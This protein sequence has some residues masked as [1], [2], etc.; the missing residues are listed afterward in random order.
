MKA[1]KKKCYYNDFHQK[2]H[3]FSQSISFPSVCG[4]KDRF[5][6]CAREKSI[7]K[8]GPSSS[9]IAKEK[10]RSGLILLITFLLLCLLAVIFP[11]EYHDSD[12]SAYHSISQKLAGQPLTRWGSPEWW[13][14]GHNVGYFR[15]H[16]PGIFWL[17]AVLVRLGIP[18]R[19]APLC[20]NF[21]YLFLLL[22][23]LYGLLR[24]FGGPEAG[25]AAVFAFVLTPIFAQYLM[26]ANQELP[27]ALA[28]VAGLYGLSRQEESWRYAALYGAAMLL[29]VFIKGVNALT[30]SL[31]SL[32]F[33][34]II[35]RKRRTFLLILS[36][37]LLALAAMAGFELWYRASTGGASFLQVYLNF[38]G[39]KAVEAGFRP[40]VK[41]YNIVW[42]LA[43]TLWFAA[44][45]VFILIYALLRSA[46]EKAGLLRERFLQLALAGSALIIL[47]FS[48]FD[49]RADRYIF[50][51]Y[52]LLAAAGAWSLVRRKPAFKRFLERRRPHL[53][54]YLGG[55]LIL[56]VLARIYFH[57][58]H[59][60]FI[61]LW[62]H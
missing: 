41:A 43:R 23:A 47:F 17:P 28:V 32:A 13:G 31:C 5:G 48:L 8:Y 56:M 61:R 11:Y 46:K 15:D 58:Y 20:A 34:L 10:I 12:S 26:R 33:W 55:L 27:L 22:Y 6:I 19:S 60:R 18:G 49:R 36:G 40:L 57:T 25:W 2:I 16:P 45:W 44:P 59:Y 29:A 37:H 21:L 54:L 42:Y 3:S 30:L 52:V 7:I 4:E 50:P 1:L 9:M 51:A 53:A 14:H 39:G 24:R 38:Q 35:C 62:A